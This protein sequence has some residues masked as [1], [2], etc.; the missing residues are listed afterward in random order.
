M[1]KSFGG[2]NLSTKN[3]KSMVH[4][5]KDI[6]ELPVLNEGYGNYDGIEFG[7]GENG[8]RIWIWDENKWGESSTGSVN[9]VFY[10]DDL[11]VFYN[12]LQAK[13]FNCKPP[14]TADWGGKEFKLIDPCGNELTILKY[15]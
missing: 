3:V 8:T 7:F 12:R 14:F 11:D 4:F 10:V 13:G 1:I 9:L 5:Y 15:S 6:I 2:I